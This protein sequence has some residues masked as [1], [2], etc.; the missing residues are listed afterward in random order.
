M[1]GHALVAFLKLCSVIQRF[2]FVKLPIPI[3][4]NEDLL[5]KG[6]KG[7]KININTS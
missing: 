3:V 5:E 1:D 2:S 6:Y 4:L 7:K